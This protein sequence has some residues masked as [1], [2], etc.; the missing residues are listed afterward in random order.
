[1]PANPAAW[2]LVTARHR[3]LDVLRRDRRLADDEALASLAAPEPAP[4]E[5]MP[6]DRLALIFAL[7]HPSLAAEA[8]VALTLRHVAGLRTG[9]VARA[10]LTSEPAMAQRLVRAR[11]KIRDA[12]IPFDVPERDALP[13][14][15][16]DVLTTIYLVFTEGYRATSGEALVRRELCAEAI[17][18]A[19]LV[20][21]LSPAEGEPRGLL[22]LLLLQDSR[23]ETRVGPDG[24]LV[25]LADQDRTRWDRAEIA[26]AERLLAGDVGAGRFALQAR[27]AAEHARA[28][29]AAATDWRAIAAR[30]AELVRL[31]PSPVVR[32]NAAVATGEALGP[33]AGLAAADE[34]GRLGALDGYHLFHATRADLLRRLDRPDDAAEAYRRARA[35]A[36]NDV[37]RA[38]LAARLRELGEI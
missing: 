25:L 27:I 15:L 18:L 32:L 14:R 17:R 28:P 23:R 8:R 2:I 26:D 1:M 22:A 36:T 30:Y 10:F 34:A 29:T 38:F 3:A 11:R 35:L 5:P 6:D 16:H 20:A 24:A 12:G 37:E 31:D 21:V 13:E 9:E 19:R 33:A 7:C 4:D